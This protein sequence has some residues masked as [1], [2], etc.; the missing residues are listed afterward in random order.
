MTVDIPAGDPGWSGSDPARGRFKWRGD[1]NGVTRINW[2][3]R[4]TKGVLRLLVGGRAVPGASALDAGQA[5]DATLT[6]DGQCEEQ[7][8]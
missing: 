3:D 8:F 7:T 2:I 1:L 4:P 5:I 6:I